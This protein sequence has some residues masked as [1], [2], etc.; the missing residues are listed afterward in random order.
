MLSP[1][2]RLHRLFRTRRSNAR[3]QCSHSSKEVGE[4]NAV[5][6]PGRHGGGRDDGYAR[7]SRHLRGR[8]RC[9]RAARANDCANALAAER[10]ARQVER[11]LQGSKRVALGVFEGKAK[12]G[13]W[14]QVI[15]HAVGLVVEL[16][17][18]L[19][20]AHAWRPR[21]RTEAGGF[22]TEH[23]QKHADANHRHTRRCGVHV[24][25]TRACK[26]C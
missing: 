13:G 23:G 9:A 22:G 2:G 1:E 18:R 24:A 16:A 14:Q 4:R 6:K 26:L 5:A 12:L 15:D 21:N 17:Q 20:H 8:H 19:V 10:V 25:G 3:G 11:R 7:A